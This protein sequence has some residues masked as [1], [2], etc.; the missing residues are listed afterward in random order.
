[1]G[2]IRISLHAVIARKVKYRVIFERTCS[3]EQQKRGRAFRPYEWKLS[4]DPNRLWRLA[5]T[6][7]RYQT[8]EARS[9]IENLP[10]D[11][12]RNGKPLEW[13]LKRIDNYQPGFPL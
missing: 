4:K 7:Q 10:A 8:L 11:T 13:A 6:L 9:W 12:L 2:S 1:M 5:L 3:G